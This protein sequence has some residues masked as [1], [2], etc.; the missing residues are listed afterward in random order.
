MTDTYQKAV[1]KVSTEKI[2]N[3]KTSKDKA[4]EKVKVVRRMHH[5]SYARPRIRGHHRH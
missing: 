3:T 4:E 5:E 2:S 1:K